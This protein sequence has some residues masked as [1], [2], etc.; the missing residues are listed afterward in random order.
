MLTDAFVF[1]IPEEIQ[2]SSFVTEEFKNL[3]EQIEI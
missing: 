1:K 2:S 3:I